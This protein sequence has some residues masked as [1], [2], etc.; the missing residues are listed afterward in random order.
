[1][2]KSYLV[3]DVGGTNSRFRVVSVDGS[4]SRDFVYE[5]KIISNLSEAVRDVLKR[6]DSGSIAIK[7]ACFGVCGPV[8]KNGTYCNSHLLNWTID[9]NEIET[10]FGLEG[11]ILINDFE[12]LGWGI[13]YLA[14]LDKKLAMSHIRKLNEVQVEGG[15]TKCLI[16]A[17]TGL[18]FC[19][20]VYDPKM[21]IY[22]PIPSEGGHI[23]LPSNSKEEFELI[24]SIQETK[25]G[26]VCYKDVLSGGGLELIYSLISG[27][28]L[29]SEEIV[30][31]KNNNSTRACEIFSRFYGRFASGAALTT[32]ASGG[33]MIGGGIVIKNPTL[34][35]CNFFMDEF[36]RTCDHMRNTITRIPLFLITNETLA[37][38]GAAYFLKLQN[39]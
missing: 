29:S 36:V 32:M 16:G 7:K 21:A 20:L 38:D 12:A 6:I 11:L 17:G 24:Q 1:M 5:S 33:I 22:V 2:K 28:S 31:R 35:E 30:Q 8:E 4:F 34:I 26:P 14:G 3:A 25:K 37:L 18:G 23:L 10:E 13:S 39:G 19:G 15:G 27:D 9:A